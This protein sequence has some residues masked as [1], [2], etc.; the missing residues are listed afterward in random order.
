MHGVSFSQLPKQRDKKI[1][2]KMDVNNLSF[3]QSKRSTKPADFH[4]NFAVQSALAGDNT[5]NWTPWYSTAQLPAQS[6]ATWVSPS[7]LNESNLLQFQPHHGQSQLATALLINPSLVR[8]SGSSAKDNGSKVALWGTM[9]DGRKRDRFNN[10]TAA[11]TGGCK[12]SPSNSLDDATTT[13]EHIRRPMNVSS[14][15]HI[16]III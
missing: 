3:S 14:N 16:W 6:T 7:T 2:F 1:L 12:T 11:E 4:R 13:V 5:K 8:H 15:L 10:V 9:G